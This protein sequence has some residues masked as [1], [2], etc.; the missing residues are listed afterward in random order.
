[1]F[2]QKETKEQTCHGH[3]QFAADRRIKHTQRSDHKRSIGVV[4]VEV[5]S[6]LLHLG[7]NNSTG[8]KLLPNGGTNVGLKRLN[9]KGKRAF[10]GEFTRCLIYKTHRPTSRSND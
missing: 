4:V 8:K 3:H 1:M 5:L 7:N 10:N 6:T 9:S 2:Q